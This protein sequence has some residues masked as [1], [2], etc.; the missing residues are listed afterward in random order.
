MCDDS[1]CI[2]SL[3]YKTSK[4][5]N[6]WVSYGLKM[7]RG[8]LT[9]LLPQAFSAAQSLRAFPQPGA[10][11]SLSSSRTRKCLRSSSK[12]VPPMNLTLLSWFGR[13]YMVRC[14][15]L[16]IAVLYLVLVHTATSVWLWT[17]ILSTLLLLSDIV[18][19]S[20]ELR[21]IWTHV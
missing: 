3:L 17:S 1:K 7:T 15:Y 10:A 18:T 19:G 20:D 5:T 6:Y 14:I 8:R 16:V 13:V 4:E 9:A 21:R 12:R 11:C 2:I